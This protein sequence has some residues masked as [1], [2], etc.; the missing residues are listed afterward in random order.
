MCPSFTT[1]PQ[2]V[3]TGMRM[4]AESVAIT[5]VCFDAN[6]AA[7]HAGL[8]TP[9][10]GMEDRPLNQQRAL[11]MNKDSIVAHRLALLSKKAATARTTELNRSL[12]AQRESTA[13]LRKRQSKL[14]LIIP[15][16]EFRTIAPTAFVPRPSVIISI[17]LLLR[18]NNPTG[19]L[20]TIALHFIAVPRKHAK[21]S[22]RSISSYAH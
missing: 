17:H 14:S 10:T 19:H 2:A 5:G 9:I 18:L 8:S 16:V 6:I 3:V 22:W 4:L 11:W 1:L 13:W 21:L 12:A 15:W 7:L 20:A